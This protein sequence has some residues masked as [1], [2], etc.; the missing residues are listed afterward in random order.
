MAVSKT[1]GKVWL[2]AGDVLSM[3]CMGKG[4]RVRAKR[5]AQAHGVSGNPAVR[6]AAAGAQLRND[7]ANAT[8]EFVR[9]HPPLIAAGVEPS[10][11]SVMFRSVCSECG[12]GAVRWV[13]ME[14]AQ[15][16]GFDPTEGLEYLGLQ[17]SQAD[18]WVCEDTTCSGGG[19]LA[20][21]LEFGGF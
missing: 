11:S 18:I 19:V 3:E 14:Q 12:T 6:A 16:R 15:R 10:P 17:A 7:F 13:N 20:R 8:A 4:R 21:D 5:R 9:D 2:T 1:A